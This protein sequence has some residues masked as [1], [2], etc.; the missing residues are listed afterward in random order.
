MTNLAL[1]KLAGGLKVWSLAYSTTS[2]TVL[3]DTAQA[4]KIILKIQHNGL[5]SFNIL[6]KFELTLLLLYYSLSDARMGKSIHSIS[7]NKT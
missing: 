5:Y 1:D 4:V 7:R 3:Y 2:K 6:S